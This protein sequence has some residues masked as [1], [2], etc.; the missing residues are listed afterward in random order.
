MNKIFLIIK[1]EFLTRVRKRTFIVMTILGPILMAAL[2]IGPAWLAQMEDTQ[3]KKIA[4]IDSSKIFINTL[5]ETE[6]IK[7]EYLQNV[8]VSEEKRLC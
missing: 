2:F 4:V 8:K 6:F 5:P 3:V 7:F 1:R